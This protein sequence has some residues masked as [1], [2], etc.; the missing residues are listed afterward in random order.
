MQVSCRFIILPLEQS[1]HIPFGLWSPFECCAKR[2]SSCLDS[3]CK[4]TTGIEPVSWELLASVHSS[5]FLMRL[6]SMR[7]FLFEI[8]EMEEGIDITTPISEEDEHHILTPLRR[9][10]GAIIHATRI[11]FEQKDIVMV[12]DAGR[13]HASPSLSHGSCVFA[14]VPL[15]WLELRRL[16]PKTALHALYIDT[17]VHH[18][19]GFARCRAELN[20]QE[21]FFIMDMYNADIWPIGTSDALQNVNIA[22]PFHC[23]VTNK[24]YLALLQK[25]LH[26]ASLE[27]PRID[28]VF[29][30]C[31]NDA[32]QGDP[33]GKTN[34]TERA[35]YQRDEMV[36]DWSRERDIPIVIMPGRGYGPSSCRVARESMARLNDKYKI[37]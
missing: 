34:V 12:L 29:Y 16:L 33:L 36:V 35:I 22:L 23:G 20:M 25:G 31:S 17:D 10:V 26:R 28:I 24:E 18:C 13:H 2:T 4:P 9:S 5:L 6:R 8:Y 11:A 30:M 37:F 21:H 1:V 14:D 19:D 3:L 15:A 32:L 7:R 27:L